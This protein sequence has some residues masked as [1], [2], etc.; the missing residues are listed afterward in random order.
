MVRSRRYARQTTVSVAKSREEINTMLRS[1]GATGF[2]WSED[3]DK[4]KAM[5]RFMWRYGDKN[6]MARFVISMPSD[7]QLRTTCVDGRNGAFSQR[8]YDEAIKRH[9]MVEH[10]EL[11][12]LLKAIFVAVSAG[13]IDAEAIFLPFI[14]DD[15]GQTVADILLPR[16]GMGSKNLLPPHLEKGD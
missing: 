8:K 13:I 15:D 11:A 3:V 1:W 12:L 10:R 14:E 5:L 16:L 7:S 4:G 2:Q 9:G 6:F